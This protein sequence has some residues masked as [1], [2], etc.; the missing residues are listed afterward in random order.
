MLRRV[1][2]ALLVVA[3][4]APLALADDD[5]FTPLFD[6]KST[7][8]WTVVGARP[9]GWSV[10]D[11]VLSTDKPGA[12]WLCTDKTYGDFVLKLEF[13][14]PKG[15]N[16]GVFL[17][18]PRQGD[19]AYTGMEIQILDDDADIYKDL[20][21]FQY[22]G[23]LYGIEA[24]K[25]GHTKPAGEWNAMEIAAE[26][27]KITVKLNGTT[28][29]DTNLDDHKDAEKSHPGMLRTEG[30]IG[31]QGL[32]SRGEAVQFRNSRIKERK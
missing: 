14:V 3:L 22:C 25:R 28:V 12:G 6:G 9:D 18:S 23:S 1:R 20:K 31:L 19:P 27:R 30:H 24:T 11:G 10:A 29:V 4:A 5:G 15:G 7:A 2:P 21:P 32:H 8:G 13:R 17:R 16:S 26:G